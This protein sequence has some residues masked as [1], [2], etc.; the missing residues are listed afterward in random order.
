M[1]RH[2]AL[3]WAPVLLT[4]AMLGSG[5]ASL[6]RAAFVDPI[7]AVRRIDLRGVSLTGAS[8]EVVVSVYN[9]NRYALKATRL[10]YRI[11]VD[12]VPV[13]SGQLR[14]PFEVA[15]RDSAE[16]RLPVRIALSGLGAAGMSM[17]TG[18]AIPYRVRG[19][20]TV[21][22]PVGDLTRAFDRSGRYTAP[23]GPGR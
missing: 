17:L 6:R 10:S 3:R 11:D 22:T 4:L 7:V 14:A 20:V 13:G 8:A 1:I 18:G 21:A 19:D 16:A 12:S 9:P 5:C 23:A 15:A 2:K